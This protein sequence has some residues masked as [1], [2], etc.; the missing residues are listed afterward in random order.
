MKIW[1]IRHAKS[2]WKEPGLSDFE[3]PL[4]KR[5]KK[6]GP[7]MAAW[8]ATQTDPPGW[9]W[10]S[11]AARALATARFVQEGFSLDASAVAAVDS[12]YEA[13]PEAIVDVLRQTPP[14][15]TSVAVVA[16]NPGLTWLANLLGQ[17]PVTDNLPTFGIVRFEVAGPWCSLQTGTATLDFLAAPK[18]IDRD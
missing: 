17:A 6:D 7:R 18:T 8:L 10:T 1:L 5:G 15:V 9:L 16:H 12:L 2:S 11:T 13:S 3:R 14:D 4:N